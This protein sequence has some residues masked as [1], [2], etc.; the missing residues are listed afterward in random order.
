[1]GVLEVISQTGG[2]APS[3]CVAGYRDVDSVDGGF[4]G[5]VGSVDLAPGARQGLVG[6]VS[7][8]AASPD[9]SRV[10]EATKEGY[11]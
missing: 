5:A 8:G 1:M 2:E 3:R 9:D 10:S 11:R 4:E 7:D 6:R